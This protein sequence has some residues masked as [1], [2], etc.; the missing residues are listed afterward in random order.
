[1]APASCATAAIVGTS[2]RV[3]MRFEA[4]VTATRRVRSESTAVTASVASSPVSGS[5]SAQRTVAPAR[6]AA[7]T[8]GR[9]F[10]SWSSRVTTTSSPAPQ[11][12]DRF[13][14]KS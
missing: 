5:K 14:E 11:S 13:R 4:P 7:C 12:R 6:S 10:A 9:T 3:P 2:G 8:H 1:M